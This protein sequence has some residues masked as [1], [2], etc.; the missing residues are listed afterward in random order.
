[1]ALLNW[2]ANKT[3]NRKGKITDEDIQR[4]VGEFNK[5]LLPEGNPEVLDEISFDQVISYF[6]SDRPK[7]VN[8]KQTAIIRQ[9]HPEGKTL[10]QI[11]LDE[12]NNLIYLP[13]EFPSGRQVIVKKLD[14]KLSDF[15]GTQDFVLVDSK[16]QSTLS[17][18]FKTVTIIIW[19]LVILLVL[20]PL[21]GRFIMSQALAAE[22]N[23]PPSLEITQNM[24]SF[25][26]NQKVIKKAHDQ[27]YEE[28]KEYAK[29]ELD[30]WE[31][32]LILK[33]DND[34]LNWYFSYF[35]QK[36]QEAEVF[37]QY[38]GE[39]VIT[40]GNQSIVNDRIE[41]RIHDNINRQFA[42]LVVDPNKANEKFQGIVIDTTELYL[43]KLSE[44]LEN[45]PKTYNSISQ[46]D[47]NQHLDT[48]K[49]RLDNEQGGE[50]LPV[51]LFG[52]Y[53]GTKILATLAASAGSK[54][55]AG[56]IAS[57]V[58]SMIEPAVAVGLIAWD[59]WDYTNGVEQN[60]PRLREDL[61]ESLHDIKKILL[62]DRNFG[63]MFA[64]N[65]LGIG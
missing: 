30:N 19:T 45:V 59:Y 18:V 40:Q 8:A 53:G 62:S 60:K 37:F 42:R 52:A 17:T 4:I 23:S 61:V 34:F 11:F 29:Q 21:V 1:M 39:I 43:K 22:L 33:I 31:Q 44:A 36:K 58:A 2:L 55:A 56:F 54:V 65:E 64:I 10:T 3:S 38:L 15:F 49:I 9:D 63:V 7:N 5:S 25:W 27:A 47:W 24:V 41:K 57:K 32:E 12:N 13:N 28:A 26:D 16:K 48:I 51:K 14:K 46:T 50:A 6:K 20:L 35:N